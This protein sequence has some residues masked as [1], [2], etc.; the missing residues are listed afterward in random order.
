MVVQ[1]RWLREVI[2]IHRAARMKDQSQGEQKVLFIPILC[3][4]LAYIIDTL[5]M[6]KYQQELVNHVNYVSYYC[7]S[8]LSGDNAL[9][10]TS[11]F[12]CVC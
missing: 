3:W 10:G 1:T 5:Q 6:E 4:V 8:F 12:Q 7:A 2:D 9:V 11:P